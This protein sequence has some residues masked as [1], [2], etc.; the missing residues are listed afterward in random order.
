MELEIEKGRNKELIKV[1]WTI[2]SILSA[3]IAVIIAFII[4]K[5]KA[6]GLPSIIARIFRFFI[7]K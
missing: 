6:T 4:I 7:K 2:S 5:I 3:V 1:I